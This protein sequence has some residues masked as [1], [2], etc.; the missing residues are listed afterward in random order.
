MPFRSRRGNFVRSVTENVGKVDGGAEES[1][2]VSVANYTVLGVQ[3]V[4]DDGPDWDGKVKFEASNDREN[5]EDLEMMASDNSTDLRSVTET[6]GDE[7]FWL[8]D[9]A[10]IK[11]V[12][13]SSTDDGA[14]GH[15]EIIVT[16]E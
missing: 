11:Y 7:G 13:I 10:G 3:L 9:V 16:K 14:N 8:T 1:Q 2:I 15:V 6:E 5:W 12:R 4:E